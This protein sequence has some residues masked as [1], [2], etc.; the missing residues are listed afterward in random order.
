MKFKWVNARG[1]LIQC[2]VANYHQN[3]S[4]SVLRHLWLLVRVLEIICLTL[5]LT[6]SALIFH[7]PVVGGGGGLQGRVASEHALA[8]DSKWK[9]R[10]DSPTDTVNSLPPPF[11]FL[12]HLTTSLTFVL[13]CSVQI[14]KLVLGQ[15]K[16]QRYSCKC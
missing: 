12:S 16:S 3:M 11:T 9:F 4:P 14:N 8:L 6:I 2:Q 5:L 7:D 10:G 1:A 15:I 13:S